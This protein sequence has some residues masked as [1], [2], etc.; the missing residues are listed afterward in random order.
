[1]KKMVLGM[2]LLMVSI[3]CLVCALGGMWYMFYVAL[4][5]LLISC[6]CFYKGYSGKKRK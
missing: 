5:L 1:M 4:L 2:F 3:W 6:Y